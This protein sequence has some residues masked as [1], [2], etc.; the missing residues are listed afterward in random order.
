MAAVAVPNEVSPGRA[1]PAAD[2]DPGAT[3]PLDPL[4]EALI[5]EDGIEVP[6]YTWPHT[7]ADTSPRRRL[8]RVSAQLYNEQAD[9]DRLAAALAARLP[10][11]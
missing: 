2:A 8:L 11:S 6:V 5:N 4:H 10:H 9:Y 3:Y 1:E 7:P